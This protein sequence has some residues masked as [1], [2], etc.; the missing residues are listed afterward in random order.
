MCIFAPTDMTAPSLRMAPSPTLSPSTMLP[1]GIPSRLHGS[2]PLPTA[3]TTGPASPNAF[4]AIS[5][6]S[7]PSKATCTAAARASTPPSPQTPIPFPIS[8]LM[9]PTTFIRRKADRCNASYAAYVPATSRFSSPRSNSS[10]SSPIHRHR[11]HS[12]LSDPLPVSSCKSSLP[13]SIPK[14][15]LPP[16]PTRHP[17]SPPPL[18]GCQMKPISLLR[19]LRGHRTNRQPQLRGCQLPK[20][21]LERSKKLRP[22]SLPVAAPP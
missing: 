4:N 16:M 22:A 19:H 18:R 6:P 14:L 15:R 21:I 3:T 1:L 13:S 9:T 20:P 11:H 17:R 8:R 5:P 12:F 2:K 7:P 10:T